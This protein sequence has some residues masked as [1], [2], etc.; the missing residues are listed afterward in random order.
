MFK[1]KAHLM[2]VLGIILIVAGTLALAY[3]GFTFTREEKVVDIGPI[4]LGA[5]R[6]ETIP[7]PPWAAGGAL[8][9]G[10]VLVLV[11]RK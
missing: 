3:K 7:I 11:S 2:R 1:A 6:Q 8:G 9:L 4:Q 5:K 10:I